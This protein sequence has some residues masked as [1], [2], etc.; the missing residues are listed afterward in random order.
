MLSHAPPDSFRISCSAL[1]RPSAGVPIAPAVGAMGW[2]PL[3]AGLHFNSSFIEP[4][5]LPVEVSS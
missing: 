5:D 2:E 1:L 4:G 3:S